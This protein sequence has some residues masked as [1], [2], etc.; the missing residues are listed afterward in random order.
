MPFFEVT[1]RPVAGGNSIPV[2][3]IF[4]MTLDLRPFFSSRD[5]EGKNLPVLQSDITS[6]GNPQVGNSR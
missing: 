1:S 2:R 3:K 5:F 6:M 4:Q